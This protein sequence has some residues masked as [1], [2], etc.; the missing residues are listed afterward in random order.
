MY[1]HIYIYIC[2][3]LYLYT[4]SSLMSTLLREQRH[5]RHGAVF[6]D[7]AENNSKRWRLWRRPLDPSMVRGKV[8]IKC[9]RLEGTHVVWPACIACTHCS[10]SQFGKTVLQHFSLSSRF[11]SPAHSA[12]VGGNAFSESKYD[13]IESSATCAHPRWHWPSQMVCAGPVTCK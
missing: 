3:Y 13:S 10:N 11:L 2:I 8:V 5:E 6:D 1:I 9:R 7:T 4:R 12:S